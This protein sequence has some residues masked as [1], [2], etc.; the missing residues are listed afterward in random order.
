MDDRIRSLLR[1]EAVRSSMFAAGLSVLVGMPGAAQA[2][3]T[4]SGSTA[5]CT[6]SDLDSVSYAQSDGINEI[7]VKSLTGDVGGATALSLSE[8]GAEGSGDGDDG[9]DSFAATVT[10]TGTNG[11]DTYGISGATDT[12][13]TVTSTGGAGHDGY[14]QTT[15]HNP[16]GGDGGDGA[17][18]GD[19]SYTM[20]GGFVTQSE[21]DSGIVVSST[22]GAGGAGGEARAENNDSDETTATAGDGGTGAA[23]GTATLSLK[24][25][26]QS[27]RQRRRRH[28]RRCHGDQRCQH[29]RR[30]RCRRRG[31]L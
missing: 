12:S 20:T 13:V 16:A 17:A 11:S 26:H 30:R 25:P 22:G 24:S 2:G 21:G 23:A 29:R 7:D 8:V 27:G 3:C 9:S 14:G 15:D 6:G 28:L 18:A 1:G 10:F 4:T 5:T 19:A 31:V